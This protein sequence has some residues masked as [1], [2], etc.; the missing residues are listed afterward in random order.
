MNLAEA[1]EI[2]NDVKGRNLKFLESWG[3]P[4]V[5]QAVNLVLDQ[6]DR[7]RGDRKLA[8]RVFD[9]LYNGRIEIIKSW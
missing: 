3:L 6:L 7:T 1:E 2:L 5:K 9:V 4:E 8:K